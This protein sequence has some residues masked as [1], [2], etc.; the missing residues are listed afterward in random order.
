MNYYNPNNEKIKERIENCPE[1]TLVKAI[2]FVYSPESGIDD[3]LNVPP[4]TLGRVSMIDG[5]GTL[6]V[7]W[8]NG[9]RLGVTLEDDIEVVSPLNVN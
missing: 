7:I 4:G 8:E 6:F 1:G 5:T 3:N 9:R 2:N